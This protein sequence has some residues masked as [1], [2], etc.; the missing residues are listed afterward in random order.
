[1]A[2]IYL[3]NIKYS[4]SGINGKNAEVAKI[5]PIVGGNRI[6]FAYYNSNNIKQISFVEI[7]N[8]EKG[9]SITGATVQEGNVLM[10][11]LSDGTSINAGQI[12]IDPSALDMSDYYN[13]TQTNDKFV[14]KLE[15][16]T[17]IQEYLDS[18]FI[19]IESNEIQGLFA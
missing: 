19:A 17:L 9:T 4:G 13:I 12:A 3:N 10:L 16:N 8:V 15:L 11:E 5:E 6:T 2:S 7:M 1:M 14:Q 18:V